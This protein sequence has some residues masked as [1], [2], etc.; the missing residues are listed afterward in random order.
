MTI[1]VTFAQSLNSTLDITNAPGAGPR[2]APAVLGLA[3]GGWV[4]A[5]T[6]GSQTILNG[7]VDG[8]SAT[9]VAQL[10]T[11]AALAEL[12]DGRVLVVTD[13]GSDMRIG[14]YTNAGLGGG[15]T[16]TEVAPGESAFSAA[17][18]PGGGFVVASM[19]L[20]RSGTDVFL[21][22]FDATGA[23][24]L[25]T[26][27]LPPAPVNERAPSVAVRP[28]GTVCMAWEQQNGPSTEIWYAL[29][30]ASGNSVLA[31]TLLDNFGT[32]NRA[33]VVVPTEAGF[34]IAYEDNGWLTGGTDITLAALTSA[35]GLVD[36]YNIS[37]QTVAP[38][39]LNETAPALVHL[40]DNVV[41][42]AYAADSGAGGT[43]N[44]TLTVIAD[45]NTE[46]FWPPSGVGG[47]GLT[48]LNN[49]TAPTIG[50][51]GNGLLHVYQQD[52]TAVDITGE[53]FRLIRV[54]QGEAG[55]D[56]MLATRFVDS[57]IGNGG[58]DTVDYTGAQGGIT[59]NLD[60]GQSGGA[61]SGDIMLDID[62]LIGSAFDDVL[63]GASTA[64]TIYGGDGND[65]LIDVDGIN[66][67]RHEGGSGTGDWID[68]SGNSFFGVLIDLLNGQT[69]VLISG[70]NTEALADIENVRASQGSDLIRGSALANT[71]QGE[72]GDDRFAA[73]GGDD[74]LEG[75]AGNDYM[76]G[77]SGNDTLDGGSGND[78]MFGGFGNDTYIIR[79]AVDQT[80]ASFEGVGGGTADVV[81]A[82]I[83]FVLT[84]G[85]D[86]EQL[87][88]T[89]WLGTGAIN[90]TG[91]ALAQRIFGNAGANRLEDG[92]GAADTLTGG[93]GND[94]YVVRNAGTLIAEGTGGGTHDA[95]FANVSFALAADDN[96][97][98][99]ATLSVAGTTAINLT[100]NT[101][102]Q[103][104][105]R[106]IAFV[107]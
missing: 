83:S 59:L 93:A 55:D 46:T 44:D 25:V 65:R 95:V 20:D 107:I 34:A 32:I 66:F 48:V 52:Q 12:T 106:G 103:V 89:S 16:V 67:D 42:L 38:S 14:L 104:I 97:E 15:S 78:T 96:I 31:P 57:M 22:F 68:Y 24:T 37:N 47:G 73:E 90:L 35:G 10:G 101:R 6:D 43:A 7:S 29:Y 33:P 36:F 4:S 94:F 1:T 2:T 77:G 56:T 18:L 102:T 75:G 80:T 49:V 79:D 87:Q 86:I 28:D 91:N 58:I 70:G 71:L 54:Q 8:L 99:L 63:T 21:R 69:R 64:Q 50:L 85:N 92:L 100:G 11:G 81:A 51:V 5:G 41:A 98:L 23:V 60:T 39:A 72:A 88:T 19:L 45:L 61:A 3:N 82:A 105:T 76:E 26:S 13:T 84:A 62:R 17:A 9:T 74:R 27:P 30:D 53:S 40:G